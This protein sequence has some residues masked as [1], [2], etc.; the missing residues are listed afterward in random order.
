MPLNAHPADHRRA[1]RSTRSWPP[2]AGTRARRL[3]ALGRARAGQRRPA[4]RA[5]R[6]R[7]RRLQG[8]HV[9]QRHRRVPAPATTLTLYEGMA[10][11][12]ALGL[13]VAVHAENDAITRELAAA[14][15]AD[16]RAA[17][18]TTSPRGRSIAELEAIAR[19]LAL[20]EETGC[21]LHVVH[22]S[23]G[24]RRRRSSPRPGRA[25][26]TSLA[27]PARTTSCS[28]DED[29]ERLGALAK[30]APP[31]RPPAEREALWRALRRGRR[32]PCRLRPLAAPPELK[33]GRRASRP[34]AAIAGCQ[35]TLACCS[36][37]R[38]WLA[39]GARSPP[40]RRRRAGASAPRQAARAGRDAD[41]PLLDLARG[42]PRRGRAATTATAQPVR[43]PPPARPRRAHAAARPDRYAIAGRPVGGPA[44]APR[45]PA[46]TQPGLGSSRGP[47]SPADA[48]RGAPAARR[49]ARRAADRGGTDLMV[50]LNPERARPE[51]LLDLGRVAGAAR[52]ASRRRRAACSARRSPTRRSRGELAAELPALAAASR[53]VGS[54]QIRNRG[55]VGGNLGTASPAGD[56]LPPLL[57]EDA[58]GRAREHPRHAPLRS[59]T[60]CSARSATRWT[61]TS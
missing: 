36:T 16:G 14:R 11:A 39:L 48:R 49:A 6:A 18:A 60:S 56:A 23:T 59:R 46:P 55:T 5:R 25:A 37:R 61:P 33:H 44:R 30:C 53:T 1:R 27:R 12:A 54:P 29:A 52:L 50:M 2:R 10:R 38:A 15:A 21:A 13:P 26:S 35:S 20:A 9:R 19:A 47:A 17:C 41:L 58:R 4:R 51:A 40:A 32:S 28:T 43:R 24:A 3:R 31:L 34:G 22:V 42:E 45:R 7:R 57:V 8:V